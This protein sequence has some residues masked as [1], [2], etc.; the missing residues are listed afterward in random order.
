MKH[1]QIFDPPMCCSTGVC[2]PE[3]DP[4]LAR[5]AGDLKWLTGQGVAVERFNLARQ[6]EAFIRNPA[7][8]R[9]IDEGGLQVL[10]LVL[11]AGEIVS[12]G[13]YPDRG[14][15][16]RFAGLAVA[17]LPDATPAGADGPVLTLDLLPA[18]P[19]AAD[20]AGCCGAGSGDC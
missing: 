11:A 9:M 19:G 17:A 6:P 20:G 8:Y 3:V 7:V 4:A 5:F 15:L 14:E 2:G 1:L 16:A 13:R 18:A 10:P 12:R